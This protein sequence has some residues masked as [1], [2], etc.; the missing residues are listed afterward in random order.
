MKQVQ[1]PSDY[2]GADGKWYPT[3]GEAF[4]RGSGVSSLLNNIAKVLSEYYSDIVVDILTVT[5]DAEGT[6]TY[7][8]S[9]GYTY[10]IA[11][12]SIVISPEYENLCLIDRILISGKPTRVSTGFLYSNRGAY[13]TNGKTYL[14]G[15]KTPENSVY[16]FAIII[17][18]M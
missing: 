4:R 3:V 18:V 13:Y 8:S 2:I 15:D 14:S 12:S 6:I 5:T 10:S 11:R 16:K 1:Y 17:G 7:E 9:L